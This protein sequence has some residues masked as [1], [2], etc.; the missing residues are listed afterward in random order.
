[1]TL[2]TAVILAAGRGSRLGEITRTRSKAMAPIA[3]VPMVGRVIDSFRRAGVS[4]FIVVAAPSDLELKELCAKDPTLTLREQRTPLGSGDA[5]RVCE[6][7]LAGP[8]FV[9]ACDSLVDSAHIIE[10]GR[11]FAERKPKALVS[12]LEVSAHESLGARSV[13]SLKGDAVVDFIEKPDSAER[14]SNTMAL[15]LYVFGVGVFDELR[16]LTPSSRGEY[17]LPVVFRSMIAAGGEVLALR[18]A[19]RREL[20]DSKDFLALNRFFLREEIKGIRVDPAVVIP[21][22][23]KLV[24]PVVI[25]QGCRIGEGC[26]IG[27]EVFLEQGVCVADGVVVQESVVT[28][29]VVVRKSLSQ[30]VVTG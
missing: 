21:A 20:T 23:T 7:D 18:A 5:L 19:W 16:K 3:G 12:V 13:V 11:L 22:S 29:G 17:E 24:A 6:A 2:D 26:T 8:F 14:L 30:A 27:P 15:P 28:R 4:R 1:M 10:L 25:E 9:S